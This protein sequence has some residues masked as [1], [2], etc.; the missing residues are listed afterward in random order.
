MKIIWMWVLV[1][2]GDGGI[3]RDLQFLKTKPQ[4]HQTIRN[5]FHAGKYVKYNYDNK[6]YNNIIRKYKQRV[7]KICFFFYNL[8]FINQKSKI[9]F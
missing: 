9:I 2:F 3:L 4:I 6:F 7:N 8:F 5:Y 1:G